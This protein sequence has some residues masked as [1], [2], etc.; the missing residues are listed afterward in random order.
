MRKSFKS[1]T[2]ALERLNLE[3]REGEF[4]SLLGPSGCGKSTVLRLI[5]GL[6]EKT[7]GT[8]EWRDGQPSLGFVFQEP[9]LAPWSD[10]FGNVW[11]PLRLKGISRA[12]RS[13]EDRRSAR[14]GRTDRIREG[15]SARAFRR[16]ENAR[17][18]RAGAGDAAGAAV[19]G[20]TVRRARRNHAL[21]SE[22]RSLASE[23]RLS[24]RRSSSSPIRS[25]RASI[26]HRGSR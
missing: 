26:S 13:R 1:G 21:P 16:D 3:V 25:S 11:L 5:A 4:L 12:R 7:D 18:D 17:L 6:T 8:I 24:G 22:R 15:L 9:T 10:V 23:T 2:I 20:R 19:D 14:S